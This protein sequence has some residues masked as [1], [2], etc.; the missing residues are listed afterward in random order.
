MTKLASAFLCICIGLLVPTSGA[1]AKD[2]AGI[3]VVLGV[4]TKACS[5]VLDD[6]YQDINYRYIHSGWVAGYLTFF[7]HFSLVGAQDITQ[8]IGPNETVAWI[9]D[10]C[11]ANPQ[12]T[13]EDATEA[14]RMALVNRLPK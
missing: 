2:T 5:T 13:L 12:R 10:Y 4:G 1:L 7:N 14:L 6:N 3:F 8:G 11:T 9:T